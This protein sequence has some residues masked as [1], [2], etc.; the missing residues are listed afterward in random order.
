[1]GRIEYKLM[2]TDNQHG[3]GLSLV[4]YTDDEF[5]NGFALNCFS[6]KAARDKYQSEL[7]SHD[8]LGEGGTGMIW[9]QFYHRDSLIH[10]WSEC[11]GSDQIAY[12]DARLSRPNHIKRANI[13]ALQRYGQRRGLFGFRLYRGQRLDNAFALTAGIIPMLQM[14]STQ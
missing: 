13:I 4:Q 3:F 9:A 12:L 6:T 8:R 2:P 1:M 14:E 11:T 7:E 5:T 10:P